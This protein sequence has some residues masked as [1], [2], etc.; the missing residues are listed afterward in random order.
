MMRKHI[1]ASTLAALLCALLLLLLCACGASGGTVQG[2]PAQ[3][4]EEAANQA[5]EEQTGQ[6]EPEP[7]ES[8]AA[9]AQSAADSET[10]QFQLGASGYA[11]LVPRSYKN[12]EVTLDEVQSNLIA[13]YYSP[14]SD[15]DFDIYE[16]PKPDPN[17]NL[18]EYTLA[19]AADFNGSDVRCGKING[20]SVGRYKSREI[21][22]G[23]EYDVLVALMEEG[24]EYIEVVFW[25]DGENAEREATDI[26]KTLSHVET[27]DLQLGTS[28]FYLTVPDGY[29]PGPVT[30][31]EA[32]DDMVGYYYNDTTPLDFDVYQ[33][34]KDGYTL[35]KYAIEEAN[36]YE[37]ERVDYRTINGIDLA[38]YYSY[39]ESEGE[40]YTVANYLFE[41]G[42]EFMEVA[43]WLDG[44]IAVK[45]TDRILSTLKRADG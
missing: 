27:Y 41:N 10:V 21:Y 34:G 45:Q 23:V 18:E 25:L 38:F 33:F 31:E 20:I 12:G 40:M 6:E 29:K 16:F 3:Q 26:L 35:E 2:E 42:N 44:E 11:I 43:F 17:M 37:A 8:A 24:D 14:A 30:E 9:P 22:D 36:R 15:M 4:E 5:Q 1:A 19:S 28:P 32:A 13:Y 7:Q 39:E